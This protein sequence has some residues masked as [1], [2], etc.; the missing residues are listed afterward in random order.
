MF[1]QE[2]QIHCE[3]SHQSRLQAVFI[4]VIHVWDVDR[5]P[6]LVFVRVE[7]WNERGVVVKT[8]GE[9]HTLTRDNGG[10]VQLQAGSVIHMQKSG[11]QQ[12][13]QKV[14]ERYCTLPT[15]PPKQPSLSWV[16]IPPK[17]T[18]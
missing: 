18:Y 11:G 12:I 17:W 4:K 9:G 2:L 14:L 8:I 5:C 15:K 16:E 7:P 3:V 13:P 10:R 6:F 1:A